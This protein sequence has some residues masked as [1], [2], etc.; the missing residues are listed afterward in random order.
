MFEKFSV[1][2]TLFTLNMYR[3]K[4]SQM[5]SHFIFGDTTP[6]KANAPSK[7]QKASVYIEIHDDILAKNSDVIPLYTIHRRAKALSPLEQLKLIS[8]NKFKVLSYFSF[9]NLIP[10]T[11]SLIKKFTEVNVG[12]VTLAKSKEMANNLINHDWLH[13][14]VIN[15]YLKFLCR[16]SNHA[17][18]FDSTYHLTRNLMENLANPRHYKLLKKDIVDAKKIV[19]PICENDHWYLL[20]MKKN[21]EGKFDI[22]CL[23]ALN[24]PDK[25]Q[26][27]NKAKMILKALFPNRNPNT[28][29]GE[30]KCIN[31]PVQS[32]FKS[33]DE[34]ETNYTDCGP[35]ILFWAKQLLGNVDINSI[36][37]TGF[38][39]YSA[40]RLD[41]AHE[42]IQDKAQPRNVIT[43]G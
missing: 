32:D 27:I 36:P 14:D 10:N 34:V 26:F 16:K 9:S 8:K 30:T 4:L 43:L 19:W 6:K 2:N 15:S 33:R 18:T 40:F 13:D 5:L 24:S 21:V 7:P 29:F 1:Q 20:F 38:C 25:R 23:D 17:L 39:D 11:R 42:L 37:H 22:Y 12:N 28:L 3:I 35:A 31:V 41:I